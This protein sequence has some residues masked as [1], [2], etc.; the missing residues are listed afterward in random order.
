MKPLKI[1]VVDDSRSARGLICSILS[2]DPDIRIIGEAANGLEA[3]EKVRELKPDLVTMDLYMPGMGGIEAIAHIMARHAVPILVVT[4]GS[5]ADIAYTAISKGALE[6]VPKPI[7][8]Q[9]RNREFINKI[10]LLANVKVISHIR[11]GTDVYQSRHP[12]A[13]SQQKSH[14]VVA[15]AS[16]TGGP[17]ALSVILAS[18][19]EDFPAPI[20]VAQHINQ[21]FVSGMAQWLNSI[22]RLTVKTGESGE[23][24]VPGTVYLSPSGRHMAISSD[25]RIVFNP[26]KG[27]DIYVPSCNVLLSS[28]ADVY[29]DQSIGVILTGMGND[30]VQGIGDIKKAGGYTIAQ[31]EGTSVVYGMPRVAVEAGYINAVL[32]LQEICLEIV[33]YLNSKT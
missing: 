16:S 2:Q 28:V 24:I 22:S 13:V 20:V 4:S 21:E 5:D 18:F 10:K 12:R 23:T 3:V 8:D 15:I 19:S 11:S 9:K 30:G 33:R 27:N 25:S 29:G 7:F 26:M 6:V 1:L 14:T 31:D 32:P 17:K